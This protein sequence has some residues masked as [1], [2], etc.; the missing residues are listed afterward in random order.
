ML[1]ILTVP[2]GLFFERGFET[3]VPYDGHILRVPVARH[4]GVRQNFVGHDE[5]RIAARNARDVRRR[6]IKRLGPLRVFV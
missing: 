4:P 5:L 2:P 6:G 1:I 3:T